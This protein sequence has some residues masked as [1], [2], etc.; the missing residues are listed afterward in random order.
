MKKLDKFYRYIVF[1]LIL[2]VS[3]LSAWKR[4]DLAMFAGLISLIFMVKWDIY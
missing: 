2:S 3:L 1:L 4:N